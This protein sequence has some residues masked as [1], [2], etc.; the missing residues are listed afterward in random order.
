MLEELTKKIAEVFHPKKIILFGS[1][2]WGDS[3]KD[4]D[5]DLLIIMESNEPRPQ[6]RAAEILNKVHPGNISIDLLV[7]TPS[8]VEVRLRMADPFV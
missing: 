4:S 7:R 1:N 5:F 3:S 6:K 2:A 8:E